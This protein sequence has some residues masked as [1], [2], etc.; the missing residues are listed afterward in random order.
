MQLLIDGIREAILLILH[1]DPLVMGAAWRSL[2]IS[3]LAVSLASLLGIAIGSW[4]ASKE[5]F[6]R[7]LVVLLCRAGMGVPTVLVGLL[8]YGMLSRRGPLGGLE[9]LYTP[10]A[11]VIGEFCLALPIVISLTHAAIASLDPRVRETA[12]T[13]GAGPMRRWLTCI[14]EARL[15]IL[16]AVLT[17]LAR[18]ITELGIAMMVGGN[19]KLRTRTLATATA[20]ETARG[21]FARGAAMSLILLLM[22]MTAM[23]AI[24]WL[25][26]TELSC[27]EK[28]R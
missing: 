26:R 10:W 11:I 12:F 24:G 25:S 17:A 15:G 27:K 28:G 3:A 13:L 23:A 19:I 18:C 22:A 8:C 4:L 1:G 20:L 5:F 2:W 7:A 6:G 16:L 21:E 14:S 9:L